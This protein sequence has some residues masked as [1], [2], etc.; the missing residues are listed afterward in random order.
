MVI[1]LIE[2]N[3][4]SLNFTILF[5]KIHVTSF[6]EAKKS[7]ISQGVKSWNIFM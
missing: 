5:D 3:G 7:K 1:K 6:I 2:M 4:V